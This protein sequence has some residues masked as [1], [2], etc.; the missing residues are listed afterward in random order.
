MLIPKHSPGSWYNTLI[1]NT[2][3]T[4][5]GED[6]IVCMI[7]NNIKEEANAKLISAAPDLL[8]VCVEMEKFLLTVGLDPSVTGFKGLAETLFDN[9]REA[10]KKATK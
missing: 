1:G 2:R 9:A 10:I 7:M 5:G 4:I 8:A 3:Y 6:V